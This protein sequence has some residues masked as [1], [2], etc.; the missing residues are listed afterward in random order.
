[1]RVELKTATKMITITLSTENKAKVSFR[2]EVIQGVPTCTYGFPLWS[3]LF[4]E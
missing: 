3:A 1:M 2:A 4:A